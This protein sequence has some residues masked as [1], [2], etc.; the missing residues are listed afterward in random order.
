[1][2]SETMTVQEAI[3]LC[4]PNDARASAEQWLTAMAVLVAHARATTAGTGA[5]GE[6]VTVSDAM[7]EAAP[8]QSVV[9]AV[10]NLVRAQ[11]NLSKA[12]IDNAHGELSDD[13]YRKA[14]D[15]YCA[16]DDVFGA[17]LTAALAA[18][19]RGA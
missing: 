19:A 7:V 15:A 4:E 5:G 1:M 9:D 12:E 2:A 14:A 10:R 13:E 8:R 17:T 16:A 6:R 18:S 3:E 11:D